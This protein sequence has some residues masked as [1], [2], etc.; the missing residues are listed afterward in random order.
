M[1]DEEHIAFLTLWLSYYSF[2]SGSMQIAKSY[3]SLE[4]QI[5]EG[6]QVSL[7]KLMLASLY[8]SL[9]LA[10]LKLKLLH[11]TSKALNLYGPMWLLQN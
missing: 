4:I 1:P 6:R 10:K 9:G 8:H 3:I 11:S 5:H 7:G 2:C